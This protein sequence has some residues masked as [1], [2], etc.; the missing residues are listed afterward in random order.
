MIWLSPPDGSPSR[1]AVFSD[2]AIQI[3]L[4]MK[5]LLGMAL[6]PATGFVESLSRLIGFDWAVPDFSTLSRRQSL[7]VIAR[8]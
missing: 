4:V 8:P 5:V 7:R 6:R 3:C 1:P 2:A